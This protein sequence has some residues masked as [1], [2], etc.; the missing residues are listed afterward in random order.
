MF[1]VAEA[2]VVDESIELF[3]E[4]DAHLAPCMEETVQDVWREE[5]TTLTRIYLNEIGRKPLLTQ[6]E[7][8]RL[9]RRMKAGD[10]RARCEMIE[11]NL[12]LVVSIVKH[13]QN[14]GVDFL[15]LIEEGNLGLMHALEKFEPELGYRFSTYATWW[16]RQ[17]AERALLNQSRTVRLP[18]HVGKQLSKVQRTLRALEKEGGGEF[19]TTEVARRLACPRAEVEGLLELQGRCVSFETPLGNNT[20][21][22][23]VDVLADDLQRM[24]DQLL[25]RQQLDQGLQGWLSELTARQR[26]VIELRF[27]L[28]GDEPLTLEVVGKLLGIGRERVRQTQIEALEILRKVLCRNG[29]DA[30]DAD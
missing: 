27:G 22:T 7:E 10:E 14:R 11:R 2:C 12:R 8:Q 25:H 15:D 5:T 16:I 6:E 26:A 18:V 3:A 1:A 13:Y 30:A 20:D 9:A 4:D 17:N 29:I 24:P 21:L 19:S 23:L 28:N